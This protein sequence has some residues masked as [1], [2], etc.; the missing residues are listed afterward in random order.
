MQAVCMSEATA[1]VLAY[2]VSVEVLVTC[3]VCPPSEGGEAIAGQVPMVRL[4]S[5]RISICCHLPTLLDHC[6]RP[7]PISLNFLHLHGENG[8][9]KRIRSP[10]PI[11]MV[12]GDVGGPPDYPHN[13]NHRVCGRMVR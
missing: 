8:D 6:Q 12:R 7:L 1:V 11:P 2:D 9:P 10:K 13:S 5:P 4:L 3:L